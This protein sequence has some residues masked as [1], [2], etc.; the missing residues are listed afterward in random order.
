MRGDVLLGGKTLRITIGALE[1]I[2]DGGFSPAVVLNALATDLYTVS[3]LMAT[4]RAGLESSDLSEVQELVGKEGITKSKDAAF[5]AL[6]AAFEG[7]AE[8]NSDAATKKKSQT[9]GS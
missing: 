4:I 2:S 5:K 7:V 9:E 3:E 8:G 6:K 1:Q